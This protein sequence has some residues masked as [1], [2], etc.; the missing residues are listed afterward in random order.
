[1]RLLSSPTAAIA[2]AGGGS[3]PSASTMEEET[4]DED[5]DDDGPPPLRPLFG[6]GALRVEYELALPPANASDD[7]DGAVVGF[8]WMSGD[9]RAHNCQGATHFSLW[10]RVVYKS[11]PL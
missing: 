1:M 8:G 7:N 9:G 5:A 4:D 6:D 2:M 3:A 11:A 10:Y